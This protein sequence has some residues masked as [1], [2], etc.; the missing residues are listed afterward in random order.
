MALHGKLPEPKLATPD[1]CQQLQ[2]STLPNLADAE[3]FLH[4]LLKAQVSI[5]LGSGEPDWESA[6]L[7]LQAHLQALTAKPTPKTTLISQFAWMLRTVLHQACIG[8]S[9][10]ILKLRDNAYKI[11]SYK[12]GLPTDWPNISKTL[13][14]IFQSN[15][16]NN[17]I[18]PRQRSM[19]RD[20][21]ST[22]PEDQW[23]KTLEDLEEAVDAGYNEV[24]D[25]ILTR[26]CT[27]V[28]TLVDLKNLE[29]AFKKAV[30][31]AEP[32]MIN[33]FITHLHILAATNSPHLD[34]VK[35]EPPICELASNGFDSAK[36]LL[37]SS[38]IHLC[39]NTLQR[40]AW[41]GDLNIVQLLLDKGAAVNAP[42][43]NA[44]EHRELLKAAFSGKPDTIRLILERNING[45]TALQT[46]SGRGHL[47]IV[48]LLLAA[49][50]DPGINT[51]A[52]DVYGR[53]AFE[54]ATF[55]SH[56]YA[57]QLILAANVNGVTALQAAA[58]GGHLEVAQLLIDKG[59]NIN[60]VI[61]QYGRTAFQ[62]AAEGGNLEVVQFLLDKG[63]RI[64]TRA[65]KFHGRTALQ[66]AAGNGHLEVVKLL[67]GKGND[68]NAPAGRSSRRTALQAAAEGGHL[69]VVKLLLVRGA[70]INAPGVTFRGRNALQAA[71]GGGH[72]SVVQFLLEKGADI[73]ASPASSFGRTAIQAAAEGGHLDVI[74][75]LLANHAD[76]NQLAGTVDGRTALQAAAESGHME[77]VLLLLQS[78]AHLHAPGGEFSG[79]NALQ[80]A[81]AGGHLEIAKLLLSK[82]ADVNA[83][84]HMPGET[85]LEAASTYGHLE[86]VRFL[87]EQGADI[88]AQATRHTAL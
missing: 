37:E 42:A 71:A 65:A 19:I 35:A 62:A 30:E 4:H 14:K 61:S 77:A 64:N 40:A 47:E 29:N 78:G 28:F 9:P 58:G 85:A 63:A 20:G 59:A 5:Y 44:D 69:D 88:N 45:L 50:A 79:Y 81:A 54:K 27:H 8:E 73:N 68:V 46:A 32:R 34:T 75:L 24:V 1:I 87:L 2:D 3:G 16:P 84:A 33:T 66:A 49:G 86:M 60:T 76:I 43:A 53:Q 74:K 36:R 82:G 15:A 17:I 10:Q 23:V 11:E 39:Y 51:S 48:K 26:R 57:A 25:F 70:E 21:T 67:L 55:S 41:N 13:I 52:I 18:E 72:S 38:D 7:F 56:L 83:Q 22:P 6:V 80:A 12:N 31:K